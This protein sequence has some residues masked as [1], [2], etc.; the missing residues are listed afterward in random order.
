MLY[1]RIC[2]KYGY[3]TFIIGAQ[4]CTVLGPTGELKNLLKPPASAFAFTVSAAS[5]AVVCARLW[6]IWR[7]ATGWRKVVCA[8]RRPNRVKDDI[9]VVV[10]LV[11]EDEYCMEAFVGGVVVVRYRR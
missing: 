6:V 1:G 5:A 9:V 11:A 3:L 4:K 7:R 2:E 10:F 8:A